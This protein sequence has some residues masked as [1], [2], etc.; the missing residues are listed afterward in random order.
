ML[1]KEKVY[2][3]QELEK[4]N[5]IIRTI[6]TTGKWQTPGHGRMML[7]HKIATSADNKKAGERRLKEEQHIQL[8][9]VEYQLGGYDKIK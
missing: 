4:K 9:S 3:L 6:T 1:N 2:L 8:V 7:K 5:S